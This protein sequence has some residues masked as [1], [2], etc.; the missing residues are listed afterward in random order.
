[1]GSGRGDAALRT[2]MN[3]FWHEELALMPETAT[4]LGRDTGRHADA[5]ARL[6]DYSAA[7]LMRCIDSRRNRLARMAA[8][9]EAKLSPAWRT[10]GQV[11]AEAFEQAVDG[12]TR[13]RMVET[14]GFA[15]A[16]AQREIDRYAVWPG[17]AC[18]YKVGHSEWV[19]LRQTAKA[20]A[21]SAFDL[22]RFH[23]VLRQGSMPMTVLAQQIDALFPVA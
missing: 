1:M 8:I 11:V 19:R 2:P 7:G 13:F 21:G 15:R 18:S 14:T 20:R 10:N 16:R 17:Q 6:N 3:A 12:G 4:R 23:D 22:K 9:P 5:G